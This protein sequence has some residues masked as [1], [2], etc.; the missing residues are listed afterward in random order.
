MI[1]V[2]AAGNDAGT[3]IYHQTDFMGAIT[4]SSF[5]FGLPATQPNRDIAAA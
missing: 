1:A 3:R 2:G 5:R 4:A